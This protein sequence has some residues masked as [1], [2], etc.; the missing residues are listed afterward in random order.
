MRAFRKFGWML[1]LLII[2]LPNGYCYT[3]IPFKPSD[4]WSGAY[5]G[6][7]KIGYEHI[8]TGKTSFEG[9]QVYS[10]EDTSFAKLSEG[11]SSESKELLYVDNDFNPIYLIMTEKNNVTGSRSEKS[12]KARF[13]NGNLD[14]QTIVDG[15]AS[16]KSINVP[17]GADLTIDCKMNLGVLRFELGDKLEAW[18]FDS[19]K[20]DIT[21]ETCTAV[22]NERI[23]VH[24]KPYDTIVLNIH[25]HYMD[26]DSTVWCLP[27]SDRIKAELPALNMTLLSEPRREAIRIDESGMPLSDGRITATP[28]LPDDG[29]IQSLDVR[30]VG[31]CD[32]SL[33][34]T[35]GPQTATLRRDGKAIDYRISIDELPYQRAAKLPIT[36]PALQRWLGN[37]KGIEVSDKSIQKLAH[38]V[39]GT[40]RNSYRAAMK[41][42]RWVSD[43][44]DP[45]LGSGTTIS[46]V[47]ILKTKSG[48]CKHN[49]TLYAALARAAGIP[50]RLV[51]GIVYANCSFF[52]HAWAESYVG[53]WIQVDPAF[54]TELVDATH[55]RLT[56]GMDSVDGKESASAATALLMGQNLKAEILGYKVVKFGPDGSRTTEV[57][58]KSGS[59]AK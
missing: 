11:V 43:N 26:T 7:R 56:K 22:R 8:I 6:T 44:L 20:L 21:Q 33:A 53:Q 4:R 32:A 50:T 52:G 30:L 3:L 19:D 25:D 37:S 1:L 16:S 40:E 57:F 41:L 35:D 46:A 34:I 59:N 55:I 27:D 38:E 51:T 9:K 5:L 18:S 58:P 54:R 48:D 47:E 42:M 36:D 29:Y 17:L 2:I 28:Q 31:I 15:K 14:C 10:I 45:R 13:L 24:D 12:I 23:T 39:A 49:A